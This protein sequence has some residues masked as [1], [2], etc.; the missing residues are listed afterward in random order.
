MSQ[1]NNDQPV[2]VAGEERAHPAVRLLA[3][4]C[5]ALARQQ[6]ADGDGRT[7]EVDEKPTGDTNVGR[8]NDEAEGG[9]R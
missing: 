9:E 6:I 8:H 4:A 3:R 2:V 5:I 1:N 7:D